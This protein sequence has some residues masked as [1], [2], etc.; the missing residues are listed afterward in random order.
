MNSKQ[1]QQHRFWALYFLMICTGFVGSNSNLGWHHI[2]LLHCHHHHHWC[3]K[4]LHCW[5]CRFLF[6]ISLEEVEDSVANATSIE[7][8]KYLNAV[9]GTVIIQSTQFIFKTYC[10]IFP[11][12]AGRYQKL[13]T[14]I[15]VVEQEL[16]QLLLIFM[17]LLTRRL[18]PK[19]YW[20]LA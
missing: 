5:W 18:E 1:C 16:E 12:F 15:V 14:L 20:T 7:F 4:L 10:L 3:R 9:C 11:Y 8:T 6:H 19:A 17:A 2:L 13:T